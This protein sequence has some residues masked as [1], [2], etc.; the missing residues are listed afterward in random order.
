MTQYMAEMGYI[1]K[2]IIGCT[3]PRRVAAMSVAKRVAEE[4]GCQVGQEVGYTIRFEDCTSPSTKIKYMTD[5]M[6]MREYLADNNLNKYIAMMLDEAHE[7]T[8]HTDVLFGLLK[9][10]LKQRSDFKLIVTS[11]TLDAEKFSRYFF[12][13]PI[14]TIPGRTFPVEILYCK[15]PEE[16]YLEAALI[17][18]MQIHLSEPAGDILVF[19]T[20]QEEIDTCAEILYSRMKALEDLAPELIIL[21][22]Y[23]ALPSEMQSRIFEPA[24]PG[25]RKCII[26]TNIAEASLTIDGIY[27]VVDPGFCKQNVYNPKL[28][29]DSLVVTPISSASARQRAGRAGRTGP[30]KC[31]RLYTEAAYLTEMLSTSIPEIQRTN[32]A[33]VVLQ[34]KAMGINDL[35]GFDFM[36]PPPLQTLVGAMESLYTL[37]ALDEEGLLTRIGR[38]MAEFPLEPQLSKM[39]IVSAELKCSDEI[40]TI[41]AM[42]SVESPFY[43]PKD[44]QSQ[45][46]NK[47]AKFHQQEGDHI[48]LLAIY[49]GWKASKFSNPWC[50]DNFIQARAMR[51]AQDVRKQLVT[52]MDKYKMD[53]VSAGKNFI[54]V[55]KC[56]VSGFFTNAAKKDPQDGYKSIVEGQTVFIHPSSALYQ[57][58]PEWVIYHEIVMTSKEYMR[59]VM[60]MYVIYILSLSLLLSYFMF[61]FVENQNG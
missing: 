16:D 58:G 47:K 5:G 13:C 28:G 15:E 3:Q 9:G 36:D 1:Q 52:I 48:T 53:I 40:L 22:V 14:F 38:K 50:F 11:A 29:M 51:R 6:L 20:G 19:L 43:R 37:D 33:N 17:T 31:Y 35:L 27:Y 30:G 60:A 46:D 2:G 12:D 39:L 10:L 42:L 18:I 21:P 4:Y 49:E 8:I 56:I 25:S 23:G 34:L 41:V 24:P 45:A 55:R 44:K 26:A 32:L 7:R 54:K 57:K 61:Y 59:N